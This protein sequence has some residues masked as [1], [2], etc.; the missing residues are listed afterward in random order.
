MPR[1][2]VALMLSFPFAA[3]ARAQESAALFDAPLVTLDV[4][5]R[6]AFL[7]DLDND[8]FQDAVSWWVTD[9]DNDRVRLR[10]WRNDGTGSGP[11]RHR[12]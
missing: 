3:A 6:Y 8:G 2:L 7:T 4:F 11:A 9:P 12:Q 1:M 10:A 5:D